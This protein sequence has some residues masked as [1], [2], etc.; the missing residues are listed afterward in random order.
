MNIHDAI[1]IRRSV[2]SYKPDPVP[3][4]SLKRILEAVRLAPSAKNKQDWKFIIVKDPE[5]RKKLSEAARNQESLVQAPIVIAGIALDPDYVMSCEVPTYAVDLAIAMEHI[6]LSAIEEG[7]GTCWVG[8]FSQ[9]EARKALLVPER[10]KVVILMPLGFPAD[11]P[12]PK[13]RKSIEEITCYE[14]FTE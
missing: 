2:R 14:N 1:K 9:K 11:Q 5:K 3:E 13:S 7:L 4:E 8:G 10:Y 12:G 6:A